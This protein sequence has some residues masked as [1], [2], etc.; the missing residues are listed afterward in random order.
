MDRV[1]DFIGNC[2]DGVMAVGSDQTVVLFNDAASH[3]LGY[4]ADEVV[5]R[6][7][8]SVLRGG[9]CAACRRDCP[10]ITAARRLT[11]VPS[12]SIGTRDRAGR[13]LSLS[14]TS[15]VVP[16]DRLEEQ[17]ELSVLVHVFCEV[18]HEHDVA[19]AAMAFA[20]FVQMGDALPVST[21]APPAN[22]AADGLTA[23]ECTVIR[24]LADGESA[25]AI[26]ERL[27]ISPRTVRNHVSNVL[28]KL[29]V[30]SRL[31]AVTHCIRNGLI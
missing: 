8:F 29:G 19:M 27:H 5:G 21:W 23:R 6:K 2:A 12:Y 20:R 18:T 7:C 28:S 24:G 9:G 30:H 10:A 22:P 4:E 26:A 14:V 17:P 16:S 13:P 3:I 31:E 11:I 15:M 25:T 1:L